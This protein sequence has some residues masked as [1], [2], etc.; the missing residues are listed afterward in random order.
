[1]DLK[2]SKGK[3]NVKLMIGEEK[4]E[5]REMIRMRGRRCGERPGGWEIDTT[6]NRRKMRG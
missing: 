4:I 3:M 5:G 1:M 6:L 2:G